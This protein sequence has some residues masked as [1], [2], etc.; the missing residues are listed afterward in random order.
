MITAIIKEILTF[1]ILKIRRIIYKNIKKR[2]SAEVDNLDNSGIHITPDY[3][4]QKDC[5]Q[6]RD[7]IDDFIN[8][9]SVNVWQDDLGADNRIYFINDLDG[10]F[11]AIYQK[12]Y[13]RDVLK[14]YLGTDNP[15][16]ML[17]A[18]IIDYVPNNKG[19]G[20]GWHRDSPFTNQFKAICYLSNVGS[21]N[22]PFEI[23]KGSHKISCTLSTI[24]KGVFKPSQYRYTNDEIEKHNQVASTNVFS[25]TAQQ[26]TLILADTKAIHRGKPIEEGSRYVLFCYFWHSKIPEHFKKLRQRNNTPC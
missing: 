21:E 23:I 24:I 26:G 9:K 5:K 6:L 20:G 4:T 3:L 18:A 7:K 16:G 11:D 12:P 1:L 17:L 22:G 10:D 8:E 2:L 19:S 15:K 14:S 25:V 13:F